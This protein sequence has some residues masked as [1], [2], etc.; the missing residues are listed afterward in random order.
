M[1]GKL[2]KAFHYLKPEWRAVVLICF[3]LVGQAMC[4][5]AL[6]GYTRSLVDVGVQQSG[7]E[8]PAPLYLSEDSHAELSTYLTEEQQQLMAQAYQWQEDRYVR[9]AH[10]NATITQLNDALAL[11]MAAQYSLQHMP[12]NA[13]TLAM[14][15]L[16]AT[17]LVDKQAI[18]AKARDMLGAQ[19]EMGDTLLMQGAIQYTRAEYEKLGVDTGK[20]QRS[21]LWTAGLAMLGA[22]LLMGMLLVASSFIS[23]RTSARISRRLRGQLFGQVLHF[24]TAEINRFSTASLITRTT[25]D[26]QQVQQAGMMMLRVLLYAPILGVGGIIRVAQTRS[27]LAWI[28]VVAV[29]SMIALVA[30]TSMLAVPK[31]KMMQK[32]LDRLNLVSRE[33]LSGVPVIRA[34]TREEYEQQRFDKANLDLMR[35]HR[36]INRVFSLLMPAM[37]LVLNL[38]TLMIIWF[39]AKGVDMGTMQVGSLL[40]FISYTMQV[41]MAFMMI[42]MS[43]IMLP[44][45]NVATERIEEVLTTSSSIAEP[46]H[47]ADLPA[48]TGH[49]RFENVSFRYPDA[50]EDVL[51]SISF[52]APPGQMTAIIGGTGSGKSSVLNMIPRF[53][54]VTGGRVSIDGVD[55]RDIPLQTLRALI[56]L[57]PQDSVL[58]TGDIASNIKFADENMPDERMQE[59]AR[60]AQAEE[61][62]TAKEQGYAEPIAQGGTNVSGGQKQRLSIARAIAAQ[63]KILL[64]DDSFSALDYR[65]D[66]NLRQQLRTH[67]CDTAVIVV[68]QR[69]ASVMQA[70]RIIMLENGTITAM[71]THEELLASSPAYQAIAVSQLGEQ[72]LAGKAGDA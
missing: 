29:A 27:G 23:S 5:L 38:V 11:P 71:G 1:G 3:L 21:Y 13:Q 8:H 48:F 49:V 46:A 67:L 19:G 58:F 34:F 28:V 45:A 64:F 16:L 7:I 41:V 37:G 66:R 31:F 10:D 39:G 56:G 17:G 35:V 9:I 24:S 50:S 70:D 47:P 36:F 15:A 61:F 55:V 65:T 22:T 69:I 44:H 57:V 2:L 30:V 14:K 52:E 63:P 6:P 33:I 42:A 40:A 68:A 59:A 54:D 20:I 53:F 72:E 51:H 26:V 43:A 18:L 25:N 4:E 62:I 32:L 12:D 60:I